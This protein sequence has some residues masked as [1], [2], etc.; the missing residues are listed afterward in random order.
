MS[1]YENTEIAFQLNG[2]RSFIESGFP[3]TFYDMKQL[4]K[5][6]QEVEDSK[7]LHIDQAPSPLE[8]KGETNDWWPSDVEVADTENNFIRLEKWVLTNTTPKQRMIRDKIEGR[9]K[10]AIEGLELG[11]LSEGL[12]LGVKTVR[13][14][15]LK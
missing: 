11:I 3:S 12:F 9:V 10:N 14:T 2:L 15:Q 1:L 4:P 7:E 13:K 5:R 6:E 8:P